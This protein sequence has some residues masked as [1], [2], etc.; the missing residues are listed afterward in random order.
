MEI[1]SSFYRPHRPAT[2]ARWAASVGQD[3][4][5]AVKLPRE[6][7]HERK[8]VEVEEPLARFLSEAGMLGDRFGPILMQLPPSLRYVEPCVAGFLELLRARYRGDVVCEPR[9]ASWFT[10]DADELLSRYRIARVAADPAV[11]PCAAVPGGW[12]GLAYWR[13]HGA[14]KTYYSAYPPEYIEATAQAMRETSIQQCWCIF[15]NTAD[16]E[17]AGNALSLGPETR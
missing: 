7:S 8:L 5:F 15:D 6:I 4:R 16:G 11:V 10:D 1:N 12:P 13:L 3:F 17:A 2:Y 9:H 14:P